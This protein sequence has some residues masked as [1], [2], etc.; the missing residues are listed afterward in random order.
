M[1]QSLE[2]KRALLERVAVNDTLINT[3]IGRNILARMML[4]LEL[5][6]TQMA[7]IEII[8]KKVSPNVS[9]LMEKYGEDIDPFIHWVG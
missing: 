4:G 9:L 1:W 3:Q 7:T 8:L 5:T 2:D 6:E